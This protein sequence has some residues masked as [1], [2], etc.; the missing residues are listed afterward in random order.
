MNAP[1]FLKSVEANKSQYH[2]NISGL[3]S[4]LLS[5]TDIESI[6]DELCSNYQFTIEVLSTSLL[7]SQAI[8]GKDI[9][10][11]IVWGLADRTIS[12]IVSQLVARGESHQGFHYTITLSSH[13]SLLH[14]KRSNRVFTGMS[15]DA[16]VTSVF[17]KAGFPMANFSMKAASSSQDMIV[18]YNETDLE[19]VDRIM[20]KC[21]WVYGVIEKNGNPI[22]TVTKSSSSFA[23]YAGSID[24]M[25]QAPTSTVRANEC[26]FAVSRKSSF[27]SNS[28]H[29]ND[30]YYQTMGDMN[31]HDSNRTDINGFG[32]DYRYGENYKTYVDGNLMAQIRQRAIDCQRDIFII[33][34]DCRAIRPGMIVNII[35]HQDY[36]GSYFVIKVDHIGS[37]SGGVNYG[38]KVK[39]LH[40]KNQAHLVP[41]TVPYIAPMPENKRVFTSFNATIE[42]EVDEKGRYIVKLPFNQD[43]EGP[44]SQPTRMVQPYGGSGHGMNFPLTKGTEVIVCGENGDLDRPII[45]GAVYNK[46]SPNPVTSENSHENKVVTR[47]G[48]SLLMDDKLGEE[49]ISIANPNDT[50]VLTLDA[51]NGNHEASLSANQGKLTIQAKDNLIAQT[52][53]N[54][55]VTANKDVNLSANENVH[56][57][58]R[59]GD[60]SLTSGREI[61]SKAGGG[62]SFEATE[63]NIDINAN[64]SINMQANQDMSL[65]SEQG[66]IEL[67]SEQADVAIASGGNVVIKS[68]SNGSIHL[69]QGGGSI[70]ID[71]GGNLNI[72]ANTITLS[73]TNIV[74]K[75]NA[76]SNN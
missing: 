14:H 22:V 68:T 66:N 7:S 2:L 34:T 56:I 25:Y 72:D 16:V 51:T 52:E 35:D 10:L 26:I 74:I 27:L 19:F 69:S 32:S 65:Y 47:A 36:N 33:D 54:Y 23:G 42:Q 3:P 21:G 43:G 67:K 18:Q 76:V 24:I 55:L 70:E 4:E 71:A 64:S 61:K 17:K 59:E 13:L 1:E 8:I 28:V 11:S 37:Q 15:I 12:G 62:V 49:K 30:Y 9:S 73:A 48:H 53:S 60:I 29:L 58:T 39:N 31:S 63:N 45:L 50:N 6:R 75:G 5:V 44:E 40:Y 46:T 41:T 20:R 38:D 57:E